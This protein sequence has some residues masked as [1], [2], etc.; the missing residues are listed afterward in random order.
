[1]SVHIP[2]PR[3]S[4]GK[5]EAGESWLSVFFGVFL[6]AKQRAHPL[7]KFQGLRSY[8]LFAVSFWLQGC[9]NRDDIGAIGRLFLHRR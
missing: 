2:K 6:L 1:M 8:Y 3:S 4:F 7:D 9:C 5:V